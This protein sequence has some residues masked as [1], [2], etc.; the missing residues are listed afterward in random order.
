MAKKCFVC[1]TEILDSH[2]CF[3]YHKKQEAIC[4]GCEGVEIEVWRVSLTGDDGGFYDRGFDS[5]A[6][7][8]KHMDIDD[9]FEVHK[10]M[11]DAGKYLS[12]PEFQGF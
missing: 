8:L 3:N 2:P 10:E 9:S 5:M 6:E 4:M 7:C 11:M 1:G 12:L